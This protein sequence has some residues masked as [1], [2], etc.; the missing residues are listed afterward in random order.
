MRHY[1][2]HFGAGLSTGVA[3][4]ITFDGGMQEQY[5]ASPLAPGQVFGSA[6]QEALD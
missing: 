1:L 5:K 6:A 3:G 2:R 4:S